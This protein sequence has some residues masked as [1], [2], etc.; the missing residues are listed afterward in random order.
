MFLD[1][2]F[3][4]IQ[5]PNQSEYI[6]SHLGGR[7]KK[8]DMEEECHC[9]PAVFYYTQYLQLFFIYCTEQLAHYV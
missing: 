1:G 5:T 2:R 8:L 7:E 9:A 6:F 4:Y 3:D